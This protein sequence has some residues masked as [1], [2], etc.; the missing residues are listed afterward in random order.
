MDIVLADLSID[1]RE[2]KA[3]M[4][5]PKNGF[6]YV[7]DRANG[8]L[9]SAQPFAEVT[10]ASKVD[11][12]TGRPVEVPGSRY[13]DGSE[14]VSPGPLGSHNWP[15]MSFNPG[16]GLAY[17][18]TIHQRW[19]YSDEDLELQGWQPTSW[20]SPVPKE[21]LG[22]EIELAGHR[23]DGIR[24]SLQAWALLLKCNS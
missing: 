17:I 5:A 16:T 13:E 2:V 1:G 9:I 24:G 20:F 23:T 10:W 11:L 8:K 3:L 21:G 6:F 15:S 22:V 19:R 12:A 4:H 14:V 18:P 7:I